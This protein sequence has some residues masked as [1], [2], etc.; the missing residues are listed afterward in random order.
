[1]S[2][3][4]ATTLFIISAFILILPA[5]VFAGMGVGVGLGKI[6][7]DETLRAGGIYDLP[8]LPALNTGTE[9]AEYRISVQYHEGQELRDDM[10]Q[11]PAKEWFHFTPA[12]FSLEPGKVQAVNI[13]LTIPPKVRPGNY[14]A[15]L[16]VQPVKKV[17]TGETAIGIAAATKLYFTIA[18][19]NFFEG[20]YYRFIS[21][22]LRY[23]PWNT[24]VLAVT[25]IMVLLWLISKKFQFSITRK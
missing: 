24:I 12:S 22:Y 8:T 14:F 25:S 21:L 16:E 5:A 17:A 4:S 19:A 10:G 23:H 3:K 20:I 1:M 11:R 15:Y 9:S 7:I 13:T 2:I 18:P 6:Q